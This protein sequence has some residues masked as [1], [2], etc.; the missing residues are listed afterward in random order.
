MATNQR[1]EAPQIV[2]E[3]TAVSARQGVI[4]GRVITV[5]AISLTL[6]VIA[7]IV[8]WLVAR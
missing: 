5:L 7:M 3:K 6:A 1:G 8:G 2:T 4:S